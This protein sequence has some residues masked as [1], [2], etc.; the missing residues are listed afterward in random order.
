MFIDLKETYINNI[1]WCLMI[2]QNIPKRTHR[3]VDIFVKANIKDWINYKFI[4]SSKSNCNDILKHYEFIQFS[5]VWSHVFFSLH[6]A[7]QKKKL[8]EQKKSNKYSIEFVMAKCTLTPPDK[9]CR[10]FSTISEKSLYFDAGNGV[11][12]RKSFQPQ[13]GDVSKTNLF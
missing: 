10:I 13:I 6:W 12:Y 9:M 11:K 5:A 4:H 2:W 8:S 3:S 1:T 7:Q